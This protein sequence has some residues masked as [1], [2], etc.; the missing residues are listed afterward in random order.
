[1]ISEGDAPTQKGQADFNQ[2]P[3]ILVPKMFACGT[4]QHSVPPWQKKHTSFT[5]DEVNLIV[6]K[7]ENLVGSVVVM[8]LHCHDVIVM[9]NVELY[10]FHIST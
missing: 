4:C 1:M 3:G 5:L 10:F 9:C 7:F 6:F 8:K 2:Y